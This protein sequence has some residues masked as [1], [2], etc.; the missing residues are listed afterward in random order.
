MHVTDALDDFVIQLQADGRSTHTIRQRERHVRTFARWL[1][2]EE[3]STSLETLDH[4]VVARFLA[5]GMARWAPSGR[6]KKATSVNQLRTSLRAFGAY[7]EDAGLVMRSPTRLVKLARC[8]PPPPRSLSADEQE[9]L[10]ETIAQAEG[11]VARRDE[12]LVRLLLGTGLRLGSALALDAGDVDLPK[13]QITV[14]RAKNDRPDVVVFGADLAE[15]L[16]KHLGRRRKGP[17]FRTRTGGRYTARHARL[18]MARWGEEAGIEGAVSPHM[19]RHS[20]A[21]GVYERTGDI[22]VV[23]AALGHRAIAST[24]RYARASMERVREALDQRAGS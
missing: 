7:L 20:F 17:L 2:R 9:R 19:L 21:M 24:T 15:R 22:A 11:D 8:G 13:M 10:V 12:M 1:Q 4:R 14:R 23:Q 3:L 6:P 16:G 18:R 5:S